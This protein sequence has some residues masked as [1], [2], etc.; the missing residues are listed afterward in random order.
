MSHSVSG[1]ECVSMNFKLGANA[2]TAVIYRILMK[3][4]RHRNKDHADKWWVHINL[5]LCTQNTREST[6]RVQTHSSI[7]THGKEFVQKFQGRHRAQKE[8]ACFLSET[9]VGG[10]PIMYFRGI[11]VAARSLVR[12]GWTDRIGRVWGWGDRSVL[13]VSRLRVKG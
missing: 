2:V 13:C 3:H 10:F 12:Y 9:I 6:P 8:T 7:L 11:I 1:L 5:F 4:S